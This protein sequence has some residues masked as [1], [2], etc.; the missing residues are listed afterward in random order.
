MPRYNIY[1]VSI[2]SV[3]SAISGDKKVIAIAYNPSYTD[4]QY[5]IK[6]LQ[7]DETLQKFI[8]H[9]QIRHANSIIQQNFGLSNYLKLSYNGLKLLVKSILGSV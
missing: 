9:S 6:I 5:G 8:F 3:T 1:E 2:T 4:N 7:Y